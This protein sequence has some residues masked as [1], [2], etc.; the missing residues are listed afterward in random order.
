MNLKQL[1]SLK[2][3]VKLIFI[4]GGYFL[5]DNATDKHNRNEVLLLVIFIIFFST[6]INTLDNKIDK[7]KKETNDKGDLL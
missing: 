3:I 4:I 2:F 7:I 6:T 1:I 5:Y